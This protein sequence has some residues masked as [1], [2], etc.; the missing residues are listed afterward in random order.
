MAERRLYRLSISGVGITIAS[1]RPL[2]VTERFAPFLTEERG[3][4]F[5]VECREVPALAVPCVEPVYKG[6]R[7]W[8][9]PDESGG[10]SRWYFDGM[11]DNA[12]FARARQ[13][14]AD[15]VLVDYSPIG[16]ELVSDMGNCFAFS[17]WEMLLLQKGRLLL[18]ASCV[19]TPL[20]GLLFS[21]PSGIG[22]ST[23]A[24]LW[25]QYAGA[26]LINGDR[27]ILSR[28]EQGWRAWGSPYAGSS[29][30][31]V[32]ES[33]VL[34]AVVLLKQAK[35]CTLRRLSGADAFRRVFAGTTVNSWNKSSV[36]H[37]CEL[38]EQLVSA[39]PVYELSCTPDR[40]AVELLRAE[41][42]RKA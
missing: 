31:F 11:Q 21:G 1:P 39:L 10:F 25:R 20:G 8:V 35:S 17:G 9:W 12:F 40:A 4:D 42:E 2:P 23:Q 18:H 32:N 28:D 5:L 15:R 6:E 19:D 14:G 29:R 30:H 13:A 34:R 22:K 33:C 3:T 37:V 27:P 7:F 36:L 24:E 38:T 26:E 16:R 41:L